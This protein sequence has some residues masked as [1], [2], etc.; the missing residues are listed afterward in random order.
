MMNAGLGLL[1]G[2]IRMKMFL[3]PV[4]YCFFGNTA[5]FWP[6]QSMILSSHHFFYHTRFLSPYTFPRRIFLGLAVQKCEALQLGEQLREIG[7]QP[8]Q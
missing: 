7:C 8:L 3:H 6:I 1:M 5:N 4:F 2:E